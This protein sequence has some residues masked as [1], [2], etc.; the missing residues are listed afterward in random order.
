MFVSDTILLNGIST[1]D[2][3][4]RGMVTDIKNDGVREII[5][6]DYG[7]SEDVNVADIRHFSKDLKDI[8]ILSVTA[9]F[10]GEKP[11]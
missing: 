11:F 7:N 8:P 4:Y 3:W 2:V 1:L 10:E 6:V 5:F 9:Q